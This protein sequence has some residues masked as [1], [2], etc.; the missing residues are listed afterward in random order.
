MPI[1]AVETFDYI[2]VGAG[3]AG[4][5]LADRLTACGRHKVLL[6]EAGGS[7]RRLA[8]K[9]PVGYG[10][11]FADPAVNWRYR[12]QP[13]PGLADRTIYW[14]RGKVIGGSS[15]INAM[16]YMR[17]LPNDFEDWAASS[18]P[19]WGWSDVERTFLRLETCWGRDERGKPKARG[20][21]PLSVSDLRD[22]MHPF[23]EHFINSARDVG[24]PT[25]ATMDCAE[26]E[27]LSY[28]RSTIR[29]G[30]RCSSADA[31]LRGARRRRNLRV[32]S[33]A[34][35]TKLTVDSGRVSE[36]RYRIGTVETRVRANLDVILSAGAVNSPQ[37]L[38]VSG[39]GPGE[40]LTPHGVEVVHD[41]PE[42]GRGLQDHLA[43]S[44]LFEATE[45][46]LNNRLG[47]WTGLAKA[48]L[49]YGLRRKGPLS[50]PINQ[51]GGFIRSDPSRPAPDIQI[52]CNPAT[53]TVLPGGTARMDRESGFVLA[54]Q[55]C[56]P[57]S[58]GEVR[59]ASADPRD[60]PLIHPNSLATEDD[61]E[62]AVTAGRMVRALATS[63]T[64]RRV[65]R[66]PKTPDIEPMTD[67]ELLDDFRNR[68]S[69]V[70]HPCCTCRMGEDA[71]NSVVDGR[72][73]VHGLQG[74]RVVD[75]SAFPSI[76]SGNINAPTLM[77]AMRAADMI[78]EDARTR[79]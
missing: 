6:I 17:G 23:S 37:L 1:K 12:T 9:V 21:G 14:P 77:L 79:N 55:P 65:T 4:C 33:N 16:A 31:F 64:L 42:V 67:D 28:Y 74:L 8:I 63:P 47:S 36:V 71:S 3:S 27:G 49:E 15:S 70:F 5:V 66:A 18:G 46:T 51:V 41:L 50:V 61:R 25:L 29:N 45:P 10:L 75:A 35:V 13:D 43:I 54:A 40:M 58:R 19:D 76:T 22:R 48:V 72:L 32:I 30:V 69:T 62:G 24:W 59:I 34:L 39:I 73:R 56:R 11:T 44:H 20:E 26:T 52:F 38:Q 53:Y 2:I 78:L 68:A 7:D 57:T 60:P